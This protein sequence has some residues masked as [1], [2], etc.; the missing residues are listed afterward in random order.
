MKRASALDNIELEAVRIFSTFLAE[1]LHFMLLKVHWPT[2]LADK[3]NGCV[4]L[5]VGHDSWLTNGKILLTRV[6]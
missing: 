2:V 3:C 5:D 4:L 6:T 1:N